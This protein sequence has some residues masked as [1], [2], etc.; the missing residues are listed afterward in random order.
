M[1][2]SCSTQKP[3]LFFAKISI[4]ALIMS[5]LGTSHKR[6]A[7]GSQKF[8][9][10]LD[11]IIDRIIPNNSQ[12][13]KLL[14]LGNLVPLYLRGAVYSDQLIF[15]RLVIIYMICYYLCHKYRPSQS[16]TASRS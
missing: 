6:P 13:F 14:V 1:K 15:S 2:A 11:Y 8:E 16:G 5:A 10:K 3:D 7:T 9:G 12:M 4:F